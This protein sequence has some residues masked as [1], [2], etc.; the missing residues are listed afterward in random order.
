LGRLQRNRRL[1]SEVRAG[2]AAR[3]VV[4]RPTCWAAARAPYDERDRAAL[5]GCFTPDG[6]WQGLIMGRDRVDPIRGAQPIADWL[7]G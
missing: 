2:I 4:R 5:A 1:R 6:L 3:E 7:I